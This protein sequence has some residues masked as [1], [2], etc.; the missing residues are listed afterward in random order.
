MIAEKH[1]GEVH[2]PT[3]GQ[4]RIDFVYCTPPLCE[5]ITR[6][7]VIADDFTE[8]VLDP[9]KLS[10]FYHPSDHRPILVDFDMK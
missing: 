9:G 10:N 2:T 4:S 7:E 3:H 8:P 6:A 1:P 5:R